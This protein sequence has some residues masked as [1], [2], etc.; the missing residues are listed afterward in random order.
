MTRVSH[1]VAERI[2]QGGVFNFL[3]C[4]AVWNL[5]PKVLGR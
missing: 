1:V 5:I 4:L 3:V 2:Y